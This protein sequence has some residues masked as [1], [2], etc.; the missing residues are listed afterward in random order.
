MKP[1]ALAIT[2]AALAAPAAADIGTHL[3]PHGAEISL[4]TVIAVIVALGAMVLLA[5]R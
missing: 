2:L 3:H 5:R 4:G 1:L